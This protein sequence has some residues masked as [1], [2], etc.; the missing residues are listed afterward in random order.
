M[1]YMRKTVT[2]I[3]ISYVKPYGAISTNTVSRWIKTV[4]TSSG[5]DTTIFKA[6]STRAATVSKV[7][8]IL[9]IDVILKHVGWS[10]DCVFQKYYNKP[11]INDNDFQTAVLK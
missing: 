11:V 1:R 6:H 3:L 8:S 5:I 4:L 9:P 7:S 2:Q 10:S